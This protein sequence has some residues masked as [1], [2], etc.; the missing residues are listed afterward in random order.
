ML[1]ILMFAQQ[2]TILYPHQF[3]NLIHDT[4]IRVIAGLIAVA[5]ITNV[6]V[7]IG[8]H[9]HYCNKQQL[10]DLE[11]ILEIQILFRSMAPNPVYYRCSG[12]IDIVCTNPIP[13]LEIK[14]RNLAC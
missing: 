10:S 8:I 9:G 3:F 14:K 1:W 4:V 5:M 11:T 12:R 7:G 13:C 6:V 2:F